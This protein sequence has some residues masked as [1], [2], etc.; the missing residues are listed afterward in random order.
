MEVNALEEPY[1]EN[2]T[3]RVVNENHMVPP[4]KE[5]QIESDEEEIKVESVIKE[6]QMES[7]EIEDPFAYLDRSDFTSEKYK[8]EVRNLPKH[9]GISVSTYNTLSFLNVIYLPHQNFS[10]NSEILL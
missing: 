7:V 8:L 2:Q 9:Y 1:F 3:E 5:N 6:D 4:L 10:L